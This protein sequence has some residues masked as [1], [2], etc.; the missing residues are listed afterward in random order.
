MARRRT[1]KRT[2]VVKPN[3]GNVP[4]S[5][6]LHLSTALANPT[7]NQLVQDTRNLMQ[8]HTAIRLQERQTNK[9]KDFIVMAAPLGVTQFLLFT[10]NE[11]TGNTHLRISSLP[12]GPTLSFRLLEYSLCRDIMKI[13]KRP[14][15]LHSAA[16]EFKQPPLLV[17]NG[18][19]NPKDADIHEKLIVTSF[20]SL[21]PPISPM[22][23][24]LGGIK[25]VMLV[26][27]NK[28]TNEIEIRHYAIDTKLVD[29]SK[30]VKRVIRGHRKLM[31]LN[32]VEDVADLIL[33]PYG[34]NGGFTSESEVE[35][36]AVVDVEE[37]QLTNIG[38]I[39]N[40]GS[41]SK[42]KRAVKLTEIGPRMK[43]KLVKIEEG[44]C[45]GKVLYHAYKS[46]TEKEINAMEQRHAV[47]KREK[48][49]RRKEQEKRVAEKKA[50]KAE[51][52]ARRKARQA[53]GEQ[54]SE[55]EEEEEEE[56]NDYSMDDEI[57][58]D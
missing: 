48:E 34:N 24:K 21:F 52:N 40:T 50:K 55:E 10:Q 43:L 49:K 58:S 16:D 2:H 7:L 14:K 38:N 19:T 22:D 30:G 4:T 42:R 39:D 17:L 37:E 6:V 33:D 44:I 45:D 26:Q 46:K 23:V 47:K 56:D 36:D 5:M 13:Q 51:K 18:F 3:E 12:H 8:P 20:Q 41:S 53:A 28:E 29:V 11:S 15:S 9:L 25:R 1:K 27:K 57:Y 31:N 54:V 35:D 32:K